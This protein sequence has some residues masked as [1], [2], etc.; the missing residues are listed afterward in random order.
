MPLRFRDGMKKPA[1]KSVTAPQQ[2]AKIPSEHSVAPDSALLR[3]QLCF[4]LSGAAGLIDQ[5][6]WTK[7]LGQLFGYSAYAVATVLAVFMG[8][9]ALGSAI[10]AQWRPA[11]K[12]GVALYSWMEFAI[13]ASTL[14]SL[15][16]IALVK[17]LYLTSYPHAGGSA[18]TLLALRFFGAAMVLALPTA[19]M[20]GTLPVLL[21]GVAREVK[22]LGIRA[23]RFYAVNTAGAVAGTIAA[24]FFLIPR[25]GLRLTLITAVILNVIAGLLAQRIAQPIAVASEDVRARR[26]ESANVQ[27]SALYMVCFAA[28]GA[29]AIA[30]ELSWTRLLATPLG[31]STYAFSLMLAVFLLGIAIGSA[32]FEKWFRKKHEASAGVFAVTQFATAAA[33]LFSL[34]M[35]REIPEV[36]LFLLRNFDE[37]FTSLV[38]AQAVT[39][40][41]A[42]LPATM[43]FGFNFPAVLALVSGSNRLS[44]EKERSLSSSVGRA[45]AANTIGAILAA[46]VGG[47]FLLP[48]IGS[49][50]LAALAASVNVAIGVILSVN[51]NSRNWRPVAVAALLLAAIGW[52]AWSPTFFSRASATFGVVLY[53][54]YHNSALTAR[55]MAET[56][57]L[58]SFKDGINATVA[59]TRSENYI[60]LKING[61]VDAS[62]LDAGTQL[63][64]GDLGA[65]FHPHPRK[66][67]IIGFGGG[68]TASAVSRFPDVE[69]IDC[70]EIEPGVL[71]AAAYLERLHRGVLQDHRLHIYFDDARNFLQTSRGK[72]DLI[73]SEPSN[74]W[75]AGVASLYTR[76]FFGV[77][78]AHLE[79][80]GNFVQWIQAY[81]L[82]FD[83]L[84]M[85]LS[86]L[87]RQFPELSLWRSSGRDFLVLAR[88]T[89]EPLSFERSRALWKTAALRQ[90]F[91][92]LHLTRPESWPSYF[93]LGRAAIHSFASRAP[94]NTD[95]R[96]QLEYSAP[97]HLLRES[98]TKE[99]ERAVDA[100]GENPLPD[101]LSSQDAHLAPVA[102]AETSLL[103]NEPRRA[104]KFLT[105]AT[106]E[107]TDQE[108]SVLRARVQISDGHYA[109][110]AKE[111]QAT[112]VDRTNYFDAQYWLAIAQRAGGRAVEAESTVDSLLAGRP[113]D[114]RALEVKSALAS[115]RNDWISAVGAQTKLVKLRPDSAAEQ[116]RLGD[117]LLRSRNVG[118]AEE[119]LHKGLQLDP[120]AFL[121]HRDLGE[122]YRATGRNTEAI[123]ELE[124]VVRL[125]PEADSKTYVSLALAYQT[126]KDRASAQFALEKGRRLF[127]DDQ[128]L[129]KFAI[130]RN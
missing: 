104:M 63:F 96:T 6:V 123:R 67:L 72:Y 83:D 28:V 110:A 62:N 2:V 107:S 24:G 29:T 78:H 91:E 3:L 115:D 7:A 120:H 105:L 98:L 35:Y 66:V 117:L 100:L 79:A 1:R 64:L 82:R 26:A 124:W 40:A 4:F 77:V 21:G 65:V 108:L 8:G 109:V 41:L 112:S 18:A 84:A 121:C 52:T 90:D 74:P 102:S 85:I 36:L 119:P 99:L 15:P 88:T 37:K 14:L 81:G 43:L 50:R 127:P 31:S 106:G 53:G 48:W 54:S 42:L 70:V 60:A 116:C 57:D 61:K 126:A 27:S 129:R 118:A 95:D 22:Q 5:V 13:A 73:I 122:L 16:G 49:F 111:L 32:L 56:E 75:I 33:V 80:G 20:G 25:M 34:W 45:A 71:E 17:Q 9:L 103:N 58:V 94:S 87:E 19:L 44:T 30:Y 69:R 113:N 38:A 10:F 92:A 68:M 101:H 76:E 46:M 97:E 93:R 47:F 12:S 114:E 23:G 55:E 130:G 125:F 11:N 86:G 59:V 51:A 89:P 39:C 128:L